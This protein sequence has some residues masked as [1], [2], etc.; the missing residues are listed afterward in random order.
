VGY[1][2]EPISKLRPVL[3]YEDKLAYILSFKLT[4][5][6]PRES[7]YGEY[8]IKKWSEAGLPKPST[9]RCEKGLHLIEKD[10]Q[11]KIGR[12]Q[13]VDIKEVRKILDERKF[14]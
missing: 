1:E 4:T 8:K 5:H 11:Y 10:I 12:L 9:I 2:D 3:I 14:D 13:P 7:Y 6:E